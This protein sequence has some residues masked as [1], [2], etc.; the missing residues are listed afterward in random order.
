MITPEAR[1][2]MWY[3]FRKKEGALGPSRIQLQNWSHSEKSVLGAKIEDQLVMVAVCAT[4][5]LRL[6]PMT[7][8]APFLIDKRGE[9]LEMLGRVGILN[10]TGDVV[11][12]CVTEEPSIVWSVV[13]RRRRQCNDI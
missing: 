1:K 11:P 4:T 10:T 2:W 6:I 7:I 5:Q 3:I 9:M 12:S 13:G 8:E